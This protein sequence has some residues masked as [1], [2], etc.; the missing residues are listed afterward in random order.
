VK[1]YIPL[2]VSAREHLCKRGKKAGVIGNQSVKRWRKKGLIKSEPDS[3]Q[4]GPG[5][6]K[7][8]TQGCARWG[9]GASE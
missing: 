8:C 5:G 7:R 4:A 6:K 3:V 2:L 9:E 1:G